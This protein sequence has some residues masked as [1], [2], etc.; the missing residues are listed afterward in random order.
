MTT[1]TRRRA[2]RLHEQVLLIALREEDGKI[3][4][5]A[6]F[7]YQMIMAAA[8]LAEL[9][10]LKKVA[11]PDDKK[12]KVELLDDSSTGNTVLDT[13]LSKIEGSKKRTAAD[14]A[15]RLANMKDLRK[16]TAE[17]L[18][19]KSVLKAEEGTIFFFFDKTYYPELDPKPE[20]ELISKLREA[21]FTETPDVDERTLILLAL[22]YKSSMLEIPFDKKELKARKTRM[23][24]LCSG[25]L[26]GQA[27]REA[28]TAA[29][30]AVMLTTV[31]LPAVTVTTS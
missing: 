19:D 6:S 21:I 28:I 9:T 30:T 29:Q 27:A 14:W 22:L 3:D 11:I 12:G 23:E 16:E 1:L 26:I 5:K 4:S 8:M 31:I 10:L 2:L 17:N 15:S 24:K 25:D 13:A 18:C 20:R 7:E